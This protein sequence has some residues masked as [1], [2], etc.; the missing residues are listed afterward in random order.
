M[1]SNPNFSFFGPRTEPRCRLVRHDHCRMAC[2]ELPTMERWQPLLAKFRC[3]SPCASR[4]GHRL[5]ATC[6]I[7][8]SRFDP[9]ASIHPSG[10]APSNLSAVPAAM[11]IAI[12]SSRRA[13]VTSSPMVAGRI[14]ATSEMPAVQPRDI[15]IPDLHIDS[16]KI[17]ARTT[18]ATARWLPKEAV[19]P[20][21]VPSA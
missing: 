14:H 8:A 13:G 9:S 2:M 1:S 16:L 4:L 17:K 11:R 19:D 18:G 20:E 10:T 7:M 12:A 21:L 6:G 5:S 15:F 3:S